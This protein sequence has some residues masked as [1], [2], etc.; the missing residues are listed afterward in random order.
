MTRKTIK[1]V[2]I[3]EIVVD[4]TNCTT[5]QEIYLAF[6]DAKLDKYL[7]T[8]EKDAVDE[9]NYQY[10][11]SH[12]DEID[13]VIKNMHDSLNEALSLIEKPEENAPAKKASLLKRFWNWI[14]RK[15]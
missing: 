6:A 3:P 2:F 4:I 9:D 12:K 11:E 10:E 14:T 7:T 1:T 8:T 13:N 5:P 15:K